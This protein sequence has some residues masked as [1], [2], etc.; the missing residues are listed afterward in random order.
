MSIKHLSL[1]SFKEGLRPFHFFSAV[2]YLPNNLRRV[3]KQYE[4]DIVHKHN[5]KLTD[6]YVAKVFTPE[7]IDNIINLSDYSLQHD[8]LSLLNMGL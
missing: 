8:E 1:L 7:P 6:L 3:V 4:C 2:M 5:K